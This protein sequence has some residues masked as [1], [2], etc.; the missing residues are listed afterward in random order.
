M[1][2]RVKKYLNKY[3][4]VKGKTYIVTGANSGLGFSVTKHLVSLGAKVIMAC[5]NL[6]K[7]TKAREKL[8]DLFPS[9]NLIL[10]EYDQADFASIEHFATLVKNEYQDFAGLILNAGVFHPQKGLTTKQGYPLTVGTNYLGVYYLL[11]QL[12]NKALFDQKFGR[13]IVFVGSLSWYRV[14]VEKARAHL[15]IDQGT[16]M[17][18]YC[19]SKTALGALS[20]YLSRHQEATYLYIPN[21]IKVL[22]M[23]PG[24]T[25]TN[26]VA[27]YPRWLQKLAHKVL[28]VFTHHPDV[29]ALGIID[30][31][32]KKEVD[33]DKIAVP[34][35]LFHISGYPSYK[36]YPH[37]LMTNYHRLIDL[38]NEV[39]NKN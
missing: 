28:R 25:S 17:A 38:T 18:K 36:K 39:I 33:E 1:T 8:L 4:D 19:R 23:H 14:K 22:T 31:A 11:V 10:V 16:E 26:I 32:L 24:V 30:L 9:A 34:R 2:K 21:N 35:G 6:N 13:R 12:H 15:T 5:R 3:H 29:A 7:A 27:S 20:Y 37:N